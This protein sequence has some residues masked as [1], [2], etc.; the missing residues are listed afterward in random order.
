MKSSYFFGGD[1]TPDKLAVDIKKYAV[2]ATYIPIKDIKAYCTEWR[3]LNLNET[4]ER[5]TTPFTGRCK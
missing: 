3:K 4:D 2:G 1:T 5:S